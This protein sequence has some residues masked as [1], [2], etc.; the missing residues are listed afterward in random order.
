MSRSSRPTRRD[1][2]REEG[3]PGARRPV[4][5]DARHAR[6]E[7]LEALPVAEELDHLVQLLLRLVEP[8]TSDHFTS[9]C[10][11]L[12]TGAGFARGMKRIVYRRRQMTTAKKMIGSHVSSVFSRSVTLTSY[13]QRAGPFL[14]WNGRH[15]LVAR[16]AP[17]VTLSSLR[18]RRVVV[19][20]GP[21]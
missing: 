7:P 2:L 13:R 3:L 16:L 6:A 14:M 19:R 5:E 10:E 15:A 17:R 9:T 8:A 12:T 20:G 21:S 18:C 11:P 1:G 4:Q